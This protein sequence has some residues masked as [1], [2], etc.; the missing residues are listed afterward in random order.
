MNI[1]FINSGL[2][3]PYV[4][5][6]FMVWRCSPFVEQTLHFT[7]GEVAPHPGADS[8]F[9]PKTLDRVGE[10]WVPVLHLSPARAFDGAMLF[11]SVKLQDEQIFEAQSLTDDDNVNATT[12]E[13]FV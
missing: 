2:E 4:Q 1:I 8:P 10:L 12:Y 9:S 3:H 5:Y 6:L 7:F 13:V 11:V